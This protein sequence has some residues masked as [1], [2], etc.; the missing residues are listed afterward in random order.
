[1][2]RSDSKFSSISEL[3]EGSKIGTSSVRRAA[4]LRRNYP[5]LEIKDVRGNLNTRFRKL[6]AE[7]NDYDAL[8]LAAAGVT[9]MKWTNRIS[10]VNM[11]PF[12][13]SFS[14]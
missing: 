13:S 10:Q 3:P 7:T 9:R 2:L 4:Q 8:L 1:M 6:D 12:L 14:H 5:G 11:K